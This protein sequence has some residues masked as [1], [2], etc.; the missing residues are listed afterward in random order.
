MARAAGYLSVMRPTTATFVVQGLDI[1]ML[2]H[3]DVLGHRLSVINERSSP[4]RDA[5]RHFDFVQVRPLRA[6]RERVSSHLS[7]PAVV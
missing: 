2:V 7:L 4:R 5:M 3:E 6:S 1:G